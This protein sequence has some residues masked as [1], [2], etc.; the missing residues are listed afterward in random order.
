MNFEI[1]HTIPA[2]AIGMSVNI[3]L[4]LLPQRL[5]RLQKVVSTRM[6]GLRIVLDG[7]SDPGNRAAVIRTCEA[8]GLLHIH[9]VHSP[10]TT[11][12]SPQELA[13]LSPREMKRLK[14]PRYLCI[15][16]ANDM[17]SACVFFQVSD[18][19]I[20]KMAQSTQPRV[21]RKN[22]NF[23]VHLSQRVHSLQLIA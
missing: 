5:A 23:V 7:L 18:H 4:D 12:R 15:G 17:C 3:S 21:C 19:G 13:R 14:S 8:L 16:F 10:S 6:E 20:R 22:L 2:P 9:M 11:P 1:L